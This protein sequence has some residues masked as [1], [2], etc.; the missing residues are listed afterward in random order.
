MS[1]EEKRYGSWKSG[2][3]GKGWEKLVGKFLSFVL[4]FRAHLLRSM[5]IP[6][7]VNMGFFLPSKPSGKERKLIRVYRREEAAVSL[8]RN[9]V[10]GHEMR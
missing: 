6:L 9:G 5:T 1:K 2:R 3:D 7:V 4:N 8:P 10:R